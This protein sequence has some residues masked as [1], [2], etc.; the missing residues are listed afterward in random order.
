VAPPAD[1][2]LTLSTATL[3]V[4]PGASG[5]TTVTI[6][7]TGNPGAITLDVTG[8]PAG[9]TA[10]ANP[11]STT[12][13]TST[14]TIAVAAST[15]PGIYPLAVRGAGTNLARSTPLTLTVPAPSGVVVTLANASAGVPAGGTVL[16]PVRLT[17]MGTAV[18]QLLELRV[19]GV[20]PGGNAWISPNFTTGDTATLQVVTAQ[21]GTTTLVVSA[22]I[23]SVPPTAN[24][25]VTAAPSTA[26]DFSLVPQT[27]VT[28]TRGIFTGSSVAIRRTNGFIG[29]VSFAA[30]LPDANQ[31]AVTF[32]PGATNGNGAQLM[33][34]ASPQVAPGRYVV[35]LRGTSGSLVRDALVT[36]NVR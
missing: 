6:Q 26:P 19:T 15:V 36:L 34:Y 27:E 23:G 28:L 16:V 13:T 32:T 17:R 29:V 24:F 9:V 21:P 20:P 30:I 3:T 2:A 7:R 25:T 31:F 5:Q 14:I 8:L 12:L 4:A 22:V 35:T 18:G 1:F 10:T 33:L 11:A